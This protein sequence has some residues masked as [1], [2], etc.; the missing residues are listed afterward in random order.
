[1]TT[2]GAVSC[3]GVKGRMG[4]AWTRSLSAEV[5]W[6]QCR[7]AHHPPWLR[8]AASHARDPMSQISVVVASHRG[9][10]RLWMPHRTQAVWTVRAM[11]VVAW[12]KSA[13]SPSSL[14][15]PRKDDTGGGRSPPSAADTN[16]RPSSLPV[17]TWPAPAPC[18]LPP[19]PP[20]PSPK[21][22]ATL[23]QSS[24]NVGRSTL[25]DARPDAHACAE[26]SVSF[27]DSE[28]KW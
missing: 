26:L 17:T 10:A 5:Q 9:S 21:P 8:S 12:G 14:A 18:P 11:V 13:P 4:V 23:A 6:Q 24:R 27:V 15:N 3:G 7:G 20:P 16:G 28:E 1:V 19:P 25:P 22:F 2:L